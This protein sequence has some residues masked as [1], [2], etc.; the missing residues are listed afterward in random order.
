MNSRKEW[1][2]LLKLANED[3]KQYGYRLSVNDDEDEG[4]FSC[5]IY[6]GNKEVDIYAENFY[7]N[8]LDELVNEAWH[9]VKSELC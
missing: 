1:Q 4:F 6:K 8:E 5:I 2:N 3:L 9:Y 7:E